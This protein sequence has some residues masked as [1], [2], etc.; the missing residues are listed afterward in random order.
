MTCDLIIKNI[1]K[2]SQNKEY[3]GSIQRRPDNPI[4]VPNLYCEKT[5]Y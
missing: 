2:Y 1:S 5:T 4:S 3:K